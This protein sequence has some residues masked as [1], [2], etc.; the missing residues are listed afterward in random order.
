M[1]FRIGI[2]LDRSVMEI[3]VPWNLCRK[4]VVLLLGSIS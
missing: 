2:F 4:E 1:M 3:V